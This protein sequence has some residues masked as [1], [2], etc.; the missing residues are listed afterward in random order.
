MDGIDVS[1]SPT[2]RDECES[3]L[4]AARL[5]SATLSSKDGP[6]FGRVVFAREN[7]WLERSGELQVSRV[8]ASLGWIALEYVFD[9][10]QL[11]RG[12]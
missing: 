6:F 8:V 10:G 11:R 5:P 12:R 9:G 4:S 3:C 7:G 2:A 1:S